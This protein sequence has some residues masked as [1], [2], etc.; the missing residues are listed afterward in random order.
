MVSFRRQIYV[1]I[2][3]PGSRLHSIENDADQIECF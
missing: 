2:G 3:E 1:G